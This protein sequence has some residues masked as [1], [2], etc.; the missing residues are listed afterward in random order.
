MRITFLAVLCAALLSSCSLLD[1]WMGPVPVASGVAYAGQST[2]R[3][4]M[5]VRYR[6]A[7]Q[8][9]DLFVAWYEGEAEFM[10]FEAS[11]YTPIYGPVKAKDGKVYV[12]S[13]K[14]KIRTELSPQDAMPAAHRALFSPTEIAAWGLVFDDE[15]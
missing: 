5:C 11:S 2:D 14:L 3:P 12:A 10:I 9:P 4:A 6:P 15:Q 7:L 8:G 13:H 1:N